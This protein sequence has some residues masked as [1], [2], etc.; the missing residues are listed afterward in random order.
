MIFIVLLHIAHNAYISFHSWLDYTQLLIQIIQLILVPFFGN[1]CALRIDTT[2]VTVSAQGSNLFILPSAYC[3]GR[4][5]T[6]LTNT[7]SC[8]L[9]YLWKLVSLF[10]DFLGVANIPDANSAEVFIVN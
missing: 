9:G 6:S 10:V 5:V 4:L 7:L 1:W 2:E 3:M 8:V